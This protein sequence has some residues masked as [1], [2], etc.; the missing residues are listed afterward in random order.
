MSAPTVYQAQ[1]P[2]LDPSQRAELR[3]ELERELTRLL[4]GAG[5]SGTFDFAAELAQ[6]LGPRPRSAALQLIDALRRMDNGTYGLCAGCQ[7]PIS[8]ERLLAIPETTVCADCSWTTPAARVRK[9]VA[10]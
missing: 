3:R 7:R 10:T 2:P 5:A 1:P 9:G 6:E 4:P 8:F